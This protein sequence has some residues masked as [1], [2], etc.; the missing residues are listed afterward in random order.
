MIIQVYR[1][2]QPGGV[3]IGGST[4]MDQSVEQFDTMLNTEHVDRLLTANV[5][6]V[7]HQM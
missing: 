1:I 4:S 2:H 5:K 3:I 6:E 7:I